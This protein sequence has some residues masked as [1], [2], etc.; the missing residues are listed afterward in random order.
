MN[1][2]CQ[3]KETLWC[4]YD[5]LIRFVFLI[6]P[7]DILT[8]SEAPTISYNNKVGEASHLIAIHIV[9]LMKTLVW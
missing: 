5:T 1:L 2:I 3:N 8:L 9:I 6:K 7:L 4:Y